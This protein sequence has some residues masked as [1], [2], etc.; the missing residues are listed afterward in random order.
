MAISD[1]IDQRQPA[2][3]G[4]LVV[5]QQRSNPGQGDWDIYGARI[6][7]SGVNAPI[8]IYVAAGDQVKPSVS[9]NLVVWQYVA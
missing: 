4:G 2:I 1:L 3:S 9:R 6:S 5:W 7:G 8:P